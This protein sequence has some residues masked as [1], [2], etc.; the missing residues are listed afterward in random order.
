VT[1]PLGKSR[2]ASDPYLVIEDGDGWTWR[3][4]KAWQ[5][6][7]DQPA[8]RWLCEVDSPYTQGIPDLGD[9]YISEISG[10]VTHR[11]PC[12]PDDALPR[13]LRHR[14]AR[15]VRRIGPIVFGEV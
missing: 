15:S 13:H 12:V 5:A 10:Y 7:P 3:V 4:L 9:T 11:D 6:D 14:E 2:K 1:N 8:A